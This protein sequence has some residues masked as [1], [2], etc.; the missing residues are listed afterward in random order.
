MDHVHSC[1]VISDGDVDFG[2]VLQLA[3]DVCES[4]PSEHVNEDR[5]THL[6]AKQRGDLLSVLYGFAI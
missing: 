1:G 3:N 2:C 4:K 5:L 6:N